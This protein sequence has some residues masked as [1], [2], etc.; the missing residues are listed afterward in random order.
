MEENNNRVD[1]YPIGTIPMFEII[2]NPTVR[3]QNI[4]ARRFNII[5]RYLLPDIVVDLDAAIDEELI[6]R[7]LENKKALPKI[8]NNFYIEEE[9]NDDREDCF[10]CEEKLITISDT[11]FKVCLECDMCKD[12]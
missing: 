2:S 10:F 4:Q 12:G 1:G 11:E 5:D 3:L 7:I 8:V 6:K 9:N